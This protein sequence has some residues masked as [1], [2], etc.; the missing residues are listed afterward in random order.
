MSEELYKFLRTGTRVLKLLES[1]EEYG[2]PQSID[3]ICKSLNMTNRNTRSI[4][5]RMYVKGRVDRI[6]KGIYRA[7]GDD[8]EY[9][10]NI[11]HYKK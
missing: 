4:V 7:K 10:S 1:T 3:D 9:N 11:I 6:E 2:G 8:R 5:S